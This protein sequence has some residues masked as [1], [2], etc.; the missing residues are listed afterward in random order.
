MAELQIFLIIKNVCII[1][2]INKKIRKSACMISLINKKECY[3]DG[4]ANL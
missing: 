3:A 2:F 4:V 1:S